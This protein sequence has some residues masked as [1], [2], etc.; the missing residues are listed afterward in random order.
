VSRTLWLWAGEED[1][2]RSFIGADGGSG[3]V[4]LFRCSTS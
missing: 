2:V 3:K 1:A 4:A